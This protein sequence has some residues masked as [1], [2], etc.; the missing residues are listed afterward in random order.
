MQ[1]VF[2]SNAPG[3]PAVTATGTNGAGGIK[4]TS[5]GDAIQGI[6]DS[7]SGVLGGTRTGIAV[8]ATCL[9][10]G[11]GLRAVSDSGWA[12]N[13]QS[14]SGVGILGVSDSSVGVQGECQFGYDFGVVGRGPNAG[15]AAFNP[16]NGNAAYL[17]SD[18][19]AAWFT[20]DV[21]ITGRLF[22]AGGGFKIDHPI[23]PG[24]KFLSH[25]FVE[26]SDMKNIYDGTV[27]ADARGEAI[28][29]LPK[30]FNELNQEFRYQL[31]P[32][33]SS[34]PELH[35]AQ[36]IEG[37]RFR[38]SG[39]GAGM[40]V[41]WQVTGIRR[42][43]WANANRIIVEQDKDVKERGNYLHPELYG[44]LPE[45]ALGRILHPSPES[46]DRAPDR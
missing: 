5:D 30:W 37:N 29:D 20:G 12:I 11:M 44:V 27:V 32:V 16:N 39:A 4:A 9:G 1:G 41:C 46:V 42:D 15:V 36:E 24:Q 6:S 26:S 38:I 10:S 35:V 33:G 8:V 34:A 45:K 19:C 18:C 25:S 31:T 13:A 23:D 3:I 40:K 2:D 21:S 28:V 17:A 22:K 43:P 7:R 14:R